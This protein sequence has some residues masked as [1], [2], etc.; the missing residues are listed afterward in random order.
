MADSRIGLRKHNKKASR[1]PGG[2]RSGTG[3]RSRYRQTLRLESLEPRQMLTVNLGVGDIAFTGYQASAPDKVSF[4]LLKDVDAGTV[5]TLSDNAWTGSA[6]NTNE[7][8]SVITF[9]GT[10]TAGTQFNYDATRSAGLKWAIG[11]TTTN[12][13]D[14]TSGNF[15]LNASGDNIFAYNGSTAPTTGSDA[16]WVAAIATNAFLTSGAATSSLTYLPSAFTL[17][18]TA[19]SLGITNGAGNENGAET[20]PVSVMGTAAQIRAAV[21]TVGNWT[22]FTAAGAQAIPPNISYTLSS[23]AGLVITHNAGTFAQGATNA[24]IGTNNLQTTDEGQTAAQITYT[25]TSLPAHGTIKKG[26]TTLAVNDTFTQQ[27]IDGNELTYSNDNSANPSDGFGF[28]VGDT[29]GNSTNGTFNITIVQPPVITLNRAITVH[30][31]QSVAISGAI[32]TATDPDTSAGGLTFTITS[33]PTRGSIT[34]NSAAITAFTQADLNAG[35]TLANAVRYT[36]TG[37]AGDT[38]SITLSLSDGSSTVIGIVLDIS[39]VAPTTA[40]Y[41]SGTYAQNFDELLPA[42]I[43]GDNSSLPSAMVL[44]PGWIVVET[45]DT[46]NNSDSSIRV[47]NGTSGTGDTVLYGATAGNERALGSLSSASLKSQYGVALVNTSNHTYDSFTL[48]YTGEQWRDGGNASAVPNKLTFEYSTTAASLT[49]AGFTADTSLDF[50]APISN[51]TADAVLDGNLGANQASLSHTISGISWGPGQTLYLRWTDANET[52]NDD[53]LA[54]DNLSFSA[55]SSVPQSTG[56]YNNNGEVDAADY[57][58]WRKTLG[59]TVTPYSGADGDGNGTIGQGDYDF[60]RSNFG[61]VIP[62][63][64][65][66]GALNASAESGPLLAQGAAVAA[67]DSSTSAETGQSFQVKA[68]AHANVSA[69]DVALESFGGSGLVARALPQRSQGAHRSFLA[70][71]VHGNPSAGLGELLLTQ[72]KGAAPHNSAT[73][74]HHN[75]SEDA[76][77]LEISDSYF[78]SLASGIADRLGAS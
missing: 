29:L 77:A 21:Y 47:D 34:K 23:G 2:R 68:S 7:G 19:F 39:I 4:V 32:L 37:N 28:T 35:D 5:L 52:G 70:S 3:L 53:G 13:S 54:L 10:F 8:T 18:N 40:S 63:G 56:D 62:L 17:G 11:A 78:E 42:P 44:P 36:T 60:W 15:A 12:L 64:S 58:V 9:G 41:S 66:S 30:P 65:G 72:T 6:L 75:A 61:N 31:G 20:S 48:A 51:T 43:P 50:T 22:T 71:S 38:D 59:T 49:D 57:V 27:D 55:A 46:S 67:V 16:N 26:V 1:R 25:V 45:A 73:P 74:P 76:G 14:V 69:L 33:G 24:L